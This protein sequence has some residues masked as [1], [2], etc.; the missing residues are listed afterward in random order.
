MHGELC[1][2]CGYLQS[3]VCRQALPT[4]LTVRRDGNRAEFCIFRT[5]GSAVIKGG[6]GK[7][8]M[9]GEISYKAIQPQGGIL[10]TEGA[11]ENKLLG[12]FIPGDRQVTV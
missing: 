3:A 5:D 9:V 6:E 11:V 10:C 1:N 2:F 8:I 7:I 12:A 4:R